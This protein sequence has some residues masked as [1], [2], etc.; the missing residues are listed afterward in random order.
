M[1]ELHPATRRLLSRRRF[2]GTGATGVALFG[3]LPVL[4]ACGDD[5]DRG[6]RPHPL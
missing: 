4:G 6:R 2:L 5:D 1:D 3:F